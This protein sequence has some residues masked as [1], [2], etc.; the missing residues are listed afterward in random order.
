MRFP[1][2]DPT[3]G[4]PPTSLTG[5][6]NANLIYG[7]YFNNTD[8]TKSASAVGSTAVNCLF[9][10]KEVKADGKVDPFFSQD[11]N[12]VVH[13]GLLPVNIFFWQ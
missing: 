3:G 7:C 11:R 13:T 8:G 6:T 2:Y 1:Y 4:N 5:L 9:N 12:L 10:G